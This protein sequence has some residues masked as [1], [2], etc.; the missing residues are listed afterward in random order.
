[1]RIPP[2]RKGSRPHLVRRN[3]ALAKTLAKYRGRKFEWGVNDCAKML[4]SHLVNMGHRKLPKIG[5]YRSAVGAKRALKDVGFDTLEQLLDSLLPRIAPAAMLAGD[6]ALMEGDEV[7]GAVTI[8]VGPKVMGWHQDSEVP[9]N[10][11]P[12]QIKAAWR[13]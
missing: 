4:R 9:V 12:L 6:V 8:C 3:D 2:P 10:I 13:V 1:M 11:V 7:L 5:H